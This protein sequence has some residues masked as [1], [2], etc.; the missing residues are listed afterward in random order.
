MEKRIRIERDPDPQNPRREWDN[1]GTMV[2]FHRRYNLGDD[3]H[4]LR[5]GDFAGWHAL[6]DHLRKE[7]KA[8]VVLPVYMYDHGGITISTSPFSCP[9]DSGQIGFT[10][11]TRE[12][13]LDTF[14][15]KRVTK[16]LLKKAT[17][18]LQSEADVY[19]AY[20]TGDVYGWV[21]E[22]RENEDAEWQRDDSCWGFYGYDHL[23]SGLRDDIASYARDGFEV[24]E[25]T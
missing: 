12:R 1:F 24:V 13:L 14:G 17:E 20:L 18:L 15:K 16:S 11:V 19:D 9:W 5:S 4:G 3:F 10:Y 22:T 2:C 21:A 25:E 23:K 7:L 6:E 8:A